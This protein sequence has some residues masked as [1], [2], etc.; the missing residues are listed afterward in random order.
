MI[1]TDTA[2]KEYAL[3]Q[4]GYP[5][6]NVEI[7]E[8]QQTDCVYN[9]LQ[10]FARFHYDGSRIEYLILPIQDGVKTYDL[11]SEFTD[12]KILEVLGVSPEISKVSEEPSFNYKWDFYQE[13]IWLGNLDIAGYHFLQQKLALINFKFLKR[14]EFS[15]NCST[16]RMTFHTHPTENISLLLKTYVVNK[17]E[18]F[19]NIYDN[20]WLKA[21][22][23]ALYRI[24]QGT[25][26]SKYANAPLPGGASLNGEAILQRGLEE[27]ERLE[28][29]LKEMWQ[30]PIDIMCG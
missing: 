4:L 30:E 27:K 10:M 11:S 22:T 14:Y 21:Y 28:E 29:Q 15:F 20:E 6:L 3:R 18:N 26:L 9:A 1:T 12:V 8:D 2:L 7:A 23:V 5:V 16:Q 17:P 19:A 25:N 13:K 24:Q